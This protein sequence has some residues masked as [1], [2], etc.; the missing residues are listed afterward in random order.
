M[1]V[2]FVSFVAAGVAVVAAVATASPGQGVARGQLGTRWRSKPRCRSRTRLHRVRRVSTPPSN[3]RCGLAKAQSVGSGWS[4]SRTPTSSLTNRRGVPLARWGCSRARPVCA[5]PARATSS[6]A[7]MAPA[8]AAWSEWAEGFC[9]RELHRHRR[10]GHI[11]GCFGRRDDRSSVGGA[12]CL[13]RKGHVGRHSGRSRAR[14]RSDTA[15]VHRRGG[16]GCPRTA[17]GQARAC[18]LQRYRDGQRRRSGKCHVPAPVRPPLQD[19]PHDRPLLG[20]RRECQHGSTRFT[21][22]VKRRR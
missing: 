19:R 20:N 16:E 10:L 15:G 21:V 22:T 11:R 18:S 7:C 3:A 13:G 5:W 4:K 2:R 1:R 9:N 17:Q 12:S 6:C 8:R 14:I